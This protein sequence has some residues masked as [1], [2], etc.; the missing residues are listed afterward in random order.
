[1]VCSKGNRQGPE[2]SQL[3]VLGQGCP[4]QRLISNVSLRRTILSEV[5]RMK[6]LIYSA[7]C[8]IGNN[9]SE[10]V[11]EMNFVCAQYRPK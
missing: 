6:G 9:R 7:K 4:I 3:S 10:L 8:H 5:R 1:M 11:V 2:A